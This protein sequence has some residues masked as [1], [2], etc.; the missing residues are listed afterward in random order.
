M[1]KIYTVHDSKAEAY[2]PPFFSSAHGLA[3]RGFEDAANKEGHPFNQHP[4]DYTLFHVGEFDEQTGII[5]ISKT[6]TNLGKAIDVQRQ[7]DFPA[8]RIAG[9]E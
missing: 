5:S 6:H 3:I 9:G 4:G 8:P 1:L 2:L 7:A